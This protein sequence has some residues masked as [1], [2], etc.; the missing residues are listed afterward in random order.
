MKKIIINDIEK[1]EAEWNDEFE[2]IGRP[3]FFILYKILNKRLLWEEIAKQ[4][5][6]PNK[7]PKEIKEEI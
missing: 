6:D 4:K 3:D 2:L 1:T 7:Q 5:E